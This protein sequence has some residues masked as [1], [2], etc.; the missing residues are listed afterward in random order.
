VRRRNC[1]SNCPASLLEKLY[2]WG[3]I[4]IGD[5][6]LG[7]ALSPR[8]KIPKSPMEE[9]RLH[10][11]EKSPNVRI[12]V[13]QPCSFD[14]HYT[15]GVLFYECILPKST[16]NLTC[17]THILKHLRHHIGAR[18]GAMG[19]MSEESWFDSQQGQDI[20]LFSQSS[21]L[22][23]T[24]G[25]S[26][27][28]MHLPM[29]HVHFR[30][31]STKIKYQLKISTKSPDLAHLSFHVLTCESLCV[32]TFTCTL[33]RDIQYNLVTLLKWLLEIIDNSIEPLQ[34]TY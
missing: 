33:L 10:E 2:T 20:C 21:R 12:K 19:L 9:S 34:T 5:K 11:K 3:K 18:V 8:N 31:F 4:V 13:S 16:I 1:F 23:Q 24:N 32:R 17:D 27:I 25:F 14:F 6:T 29:Q 22:G 26:I 28:K 7:V 30:E 15:K